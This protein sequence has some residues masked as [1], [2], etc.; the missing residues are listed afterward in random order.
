MGQVRLLRLAHQ[1][2]RHDEDGETPQRGCA[3]RDGHD[4]RDEAVDEVVQP[5]PRE[6][7]AEDREPALVPLHRERD[8][9]EA[10]VDPE[11][12]KAGEDARDDHRDLGG[13]SCEVEVPGRG[14]DACCRERRERERADVEEDLMRP[15]PLR[16]PVD[17]RDR[18]RD[19]ERSP[20]PEQRGAGDRSD[21]AER[22]RATADLVA[23]RQRDGLA[24]SDE[25]DDRE[26]AGDV[27]R[28]AEDEAVDACDD[29]RE[30]HSADEQTEAA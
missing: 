26:Q 11:V 27:G 30:A 21:G 17:D 12:D 20:R 8:A 22:D 28:A 19:R 13:R 10:H 18:D 2:E 16:A 25:R 6:A 15:D 24:D 29:S 9:D 23:D 1:E 14:E 5:E 3:V 7:L 4:A